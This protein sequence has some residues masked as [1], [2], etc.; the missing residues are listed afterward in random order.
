MHLVLASASPRRRALLEA[1]GIACTVD[2]VAVD[3]R[4]RAGESPPAYVERLALEKAERVA[5]RHPDRLVLGADTAVVV[6]DLVLGKPVD[7]A[8]AVRMLR[9]LAG[10]AH[11]VLTGFAII[12][13]GQRVSAVE[14]TTV[15]FSSL[16]E[17]EIASYVASGEPRDKAG[18]YAIQ[19]L[20]S[21]F[22][23]RIAGSY[24]NVV[25]LPVAAVSDALR[26]LGG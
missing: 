22:V 24:A 13:R 25:G 6:D 19:G 3:E 10:R 4:R 12:G 5:A 8:D 23:P 11:E 20:A 9:L 14:Q 7:D 26:R 1:A 18:A 17:P 21:A 16:T 15:W 2:V